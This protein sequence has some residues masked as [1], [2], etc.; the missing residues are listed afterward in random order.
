MD[1]G[2]ITESLVD[3]LLKYSPT[4]EELAGAEKYKDYTGK[5]RVAE[6]FFVQ[7]LGLI[8]GAD[9]EQLLIALKFKFGFREWADKLLE[10]H[11]RIPSVI[12][13]LL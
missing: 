2:L 9:Y 8:G 5:L 11:Y 7:I 3:S 4:P 10:V 1:Y 13:S 6:S 12:L